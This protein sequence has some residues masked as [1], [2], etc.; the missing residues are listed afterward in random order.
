[1]V[2]SLLDGNYED[3][4]KMSSQAGAGGLLTDDALE[5]VRKQLQENPSL[6]VSTGIPLEALNDPVLFKDF[7]QNSMN[8]LFGGKDMGDLEELAQQF[9]DQFASLG[10]NLEEQFGDLGAQFQQFQDQ[11]NQLNEQQQ[12]PSQTKGN[13]RS[14]GGKTASSAS[15][16]KKSTTSKD[17][18]KR[19][20]RRVKRNA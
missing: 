12:Q 19:E 9:Q 6:A 10:G 14:T 15:S 1:M 20:V 7:M 13:K 11:L 4:L 3:I 2:Y 18:K 16:S 17:S 5:T 8:S